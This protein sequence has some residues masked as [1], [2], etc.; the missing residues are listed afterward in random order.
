MEFQAVYV[1]M[2]KKSECNNLQILFDLYSN[3]YSK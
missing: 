1:Q 2:K 3:E